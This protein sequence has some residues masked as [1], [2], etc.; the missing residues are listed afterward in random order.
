VPDVV[1]GTLT[2]LGATGIVA[3]K[4]FGAHAAASLAGA[5]LRHAAEQAQLCVWTGGTTATCS[6]GPRSARRMS[7]ATPNCSPRKR[8]RLRRTLKHY[9]HL[10][11]HLLQPP[12]REHIRGR[13]GRRL[14]AAA[15]N[16]S[17]AATRCSRSGR[18]IR[19]TMDA[20]SAR[21]ARWPSRHTRDRPA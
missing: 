21:G 16:A 15:L 8:L 1:D 3:Q 9:S 12:Q 5:E 19:A 4:R 11:N 18:G 20:I 14:V 10:Y 6:S 2:A 13:P 7:L 17:N